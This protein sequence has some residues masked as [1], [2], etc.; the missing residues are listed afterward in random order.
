METYQRDR[1]FL[2]ARIME[3]DTDVREFVLEDD[4]EFTDE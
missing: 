3:I 2:D 1:F 4:F